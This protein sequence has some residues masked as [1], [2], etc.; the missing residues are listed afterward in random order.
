[1]AGPLATGRCRRVPRGALLNAYGHHT[2][3]TPSYTNHELYVGSKS[4]FLTAYYADRRAEELG[5]LRQLVPHLENCPRRVWLLSLVTKQDL[6][7]SRQGEVEAHYLRGEYAAEVERVRRALGDRSFR[8]ET[9]FLALTIRN[10]ETAA[11]ERLQPNE[12]GYD[13][14]RLASSLRQ[15]FAAL[16]ELQV[17][18][19]G[20]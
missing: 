5:G 3:A 12:A 16:A 2:L 1:M 11:R 20:S 15:L 6:W 8:Q 18:E 4:E 17:W 9:V 7:G 19:E 10:L 14:A 13:M